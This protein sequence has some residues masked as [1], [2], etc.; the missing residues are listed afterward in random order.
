MTDYYFACTKEHGVCVKFQI[1]QIQPTHCSL[2]P[3][4]HIPLEKLFHQEKTE[5][6]TSHTSSG[7][8]SKEHDLHNVKIMMIIRVL[9]QS[10]QSLPVCIV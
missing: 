3:L 5:M 4:Q 1:H 6:Q 7:E 10:L 8:K 9:T 2:L